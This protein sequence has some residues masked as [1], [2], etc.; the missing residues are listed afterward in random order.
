MDRGLLEPDRKDCESCEVI[1][2]Y[3][4]DEIIEGLLEW[5]VMTQIYDICRK[6]FQP[7]KLINILSF[8]FSVNINLKSF[9]R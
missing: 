8:Y 7:T 9:V 3:V 2:L 1:Y 6:P 5:A 4:P